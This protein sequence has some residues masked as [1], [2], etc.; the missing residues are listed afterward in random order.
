M[1]DVK[2]TL[3]TVNALTP[4][5]PLSLTVMVVAPALPPVTSPWLPAALLTFATLAV[6]ELQVALSVRSFVVLFLIVACGVELQR[7]SCCDRRIYRFY[8]N[9]LEVPHQTRAPASPSAC[10]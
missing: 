6:E 5:L 1:I 9:R 8:R 2:V 10:L 4:F 7:C 3:V